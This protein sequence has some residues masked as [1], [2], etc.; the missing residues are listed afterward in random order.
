MSVHHL[1]MQV[2]DILYINVT[3]INFESGED[4]LP[5]GMQG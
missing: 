3:Q 5:T 2:H 4:D 1:Y